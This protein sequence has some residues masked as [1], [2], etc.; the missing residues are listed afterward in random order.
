MKSTRQLITAAIGSFICFSCNVKQ[1]PNNSQDSVIQEVKEYG[2]PRREKVLTA[3]EQA[4]LTP[5]YII[6]SL[7]QGNERFVDN[8]ITL[9]NHS[10]MVRNAS[11]G[12]Y[13]KAV[14]LSCVDSR[15]PVED[16]FDKGIGDMFVVRIAGNFSNADILGSLEFACKVSGAKVIVVL[17]HES[18]GA[19][20]SAIDGVKLGNITTMLDKI[21]PA[22][23]KAQ[24]FKGVKTSKNPAFVEYVSKQNVLNTISNIKK[25]S[26]ILKQMEEHGTLK[27]VGAYYNLKTGEVKFL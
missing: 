17:G 24:D 12:Q 15:I 5:D 27:I 16:V 25:N 11:L 13:P 8:N 7:K 18:C 3:A 4:L 10:A 22:V 2:P 21:R 23:N 14:I 26:P 20:K 1:A 9:R 19:I 6:K